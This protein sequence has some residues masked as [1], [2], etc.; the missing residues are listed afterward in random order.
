MR[1]LGTMV[2]CRQPLLP[3]AADLVEIDTLPAGSACCL[4]N[5]DAKDDNGERQNE[6][7]K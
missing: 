6:R 4:E 2:L 7:G 1:I 5:S 3:Q